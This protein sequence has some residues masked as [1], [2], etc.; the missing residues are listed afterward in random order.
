MRVRVDEAGHQKVWPMVDC[1][2][3]LAGLPRHVGI[4]AGSNDPAIADEQASVLLIAAG[5]VI[6]RAVGPAEKGEDTA[7]QKRFGHGVISAP[8][9]TMRR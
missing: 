4:A 5:R 3:A 9:R 8:P 1:L 2:R 6:V 7:T